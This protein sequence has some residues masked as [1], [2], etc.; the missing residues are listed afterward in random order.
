LA[1]ANAGLLAFYTAFKLSDLAMRGQLGLLFVPNLQ[2]VLFWLELG[3][4]AAIPAVLMANPRVR[5]DKNKLFATA[6][7]V[8]AGGILNRL[9][10]SVFGM[11]T[12]TGPVYFPSWMEIVL[13]LAMVSVGVVVFTIAVRYLPVFPEEQELEAVPA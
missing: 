12:Y 4:G 7:M 10:V 1:R 5:A 2:A 8:V 3:I 6:A 13:T 11:W 9:N